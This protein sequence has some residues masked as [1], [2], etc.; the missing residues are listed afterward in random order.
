[1]HRLFL[2][3]LVCFYFITVLQGVH[4][5]RKYVSNVCAFVVGLLHSVSLPCSYLQMTA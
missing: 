2:L 1:M 4:I 5:Q 3:L